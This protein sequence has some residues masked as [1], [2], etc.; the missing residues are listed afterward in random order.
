MNL[1]ENKMKSFK[2]I[3]VLLFVVSFFAGCSFSGNAPR[4]DRYSLKYDRDC[5]EHKPINEHL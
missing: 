1:K 4:C 3:V 5:G 2:K